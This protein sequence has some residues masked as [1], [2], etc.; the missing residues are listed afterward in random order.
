M[1]WSVLSSGPSYL[2]GFRLGFFSLFF[3]F[4]LVCSQLV[5]LRDALHPQ[6][7]QLFSTWGGCGFHDVCSISG[8]GEGSFQLGWG[9]S[10][11]SLSSSSTPG[12]IAGTSQGQ[13]VSKGY[14]SSCA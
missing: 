6:G 2:S 11:H 7:M 14:C 3:L 9:G 4:Y 12:W 13:R 8:A 5:L 1:V 10:S